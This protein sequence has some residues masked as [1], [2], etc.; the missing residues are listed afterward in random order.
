MSQNSEFRAIA[1]AIE[2]G[3]S[4]SIRGEVDAATRRAILDALSAAAVGATHLELRNLREV[5]CSS[6]MKRD[7]S[8]STNIFFTEYSSAGPLASLFNASAIHAFD[9]DDTHDAAIVHCMAPILPAAYTGLAKSKDFEKFVKGVAAGTELACNL[10]LTRGHYA[11][12]HYTA[13][14]GAMGA[15]LAYMIA[16]GESDDLAAAAVGNAYTFAGGNKQCVLDSSIMKRMLPG[17]AA[18]NGVV[19]GDAAIAGFSGVDNWI[20]GTIRPH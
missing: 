2:V 12:W 14:S 15:A 16:R 11:G 4:T 13:V 9:F 18:Q 6:R 17:Y 1:R 19:A 5:L 10:A 7:K 20:S 3:E 8:D